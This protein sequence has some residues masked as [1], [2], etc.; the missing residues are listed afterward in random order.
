L[1]LSEGS[2]IN[3]KRRSEWDGHFQHGPVFLSFSE[4]TVT[5]TGHEGEDVDHFPLVKK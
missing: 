1:H 5:S 3:N 2:K 4:T